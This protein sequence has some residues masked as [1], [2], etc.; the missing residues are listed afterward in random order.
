MPK[1]TPRTTTVPRMP[2]CASASFSVPRTPTHSNTTS[3][4]RP[5]RPC[6][7]DPGCSRAGSAVAVA[8]S[9][10]ASAARPSAGSDT[11]VTAPIARHQRRVVRPIGPAPITRQPVPA[12]TGAIRTPCNATA[13]GSTSAAARNPMPSGMRRQLSGCT[14][15]Y[16]A[17]APGRSPSPSERMVVQRMP[18]PATHAAHDPHAM[19]GRATTG[20]PTSQPD[21]P[22][23]SAAT[24]PANSWPIT[25]PGGSVCAACRSEPQMPQSRTRRSSSPGSGSGRGTSST[26]RRPASLSTAARTGHLLER[27]DAIPWLAS[28][29]TRAPRQRESGCHEPAC[30]QRTYAA[31][32]PTSSS[33][34]KRPYAAILIAWRRMKKLPTGCSLRRRLPPSAIH[35]RSSSS[36]RTRSSKSL[37]QNP[38]T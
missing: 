16:S 36:P 7:R 19:Y 20:S 17:Y 15:T 38:G 27:G 26:A 28:R 12:A 4:S 24:S 11:T 13:S 31:S 9:R 23:P 10:R 37:P 32:A 25:V 34:R 3:G 33:A 35:S 22:E 29:S 1:H 2:A 30:T 18:S 14:R 8:P 21:T 6:R 5:V